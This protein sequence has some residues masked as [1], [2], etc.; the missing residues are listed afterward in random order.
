M[1]KL[2]GVSAQPLEE[3]G[4]LG[5]WHAHLVRF[6][7]VQCVLFCHDETRYCLF[8]PGMRARQLA[9]LGRWHREVF[10]ASL[11]TE[12]IADPVIARVDAALGPARFDAKTD[13]SVLASMNI[14]QWDLG[15]YVSREDHVVDA[16]ALL[17]SRRLNERPVEAKGKPL[18]PAR[19]MR[20][21][22]ARLA[23]GV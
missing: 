13:R 18:W 19:A 1:A 15:V 3:A 22:V 11:A 2:P 8:L 10:L 23:A 14:A 17:V 21:C 7:R 20:D 4:S 16:D 6:D 12:G 9:E 5:A